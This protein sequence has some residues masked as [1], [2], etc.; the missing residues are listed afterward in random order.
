MYVDENDKKMP[1]MTQG[2]YVGENDQKMPCMTQ[3][4]YV[5]ENDPKMP[6]MQADTDTRRITCKRPCLVSAY[7]R[8]VGRSDEDVYQ[9]GGEG[10]QDVGEDVLHGIGAT[11]HLDVRVGGAR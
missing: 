5:D 11:I 2:M 6:C 8:Q 10:E 9:L 3:G 7:L 1:C 4:M